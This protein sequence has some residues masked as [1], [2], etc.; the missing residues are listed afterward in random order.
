[1]VHKKKKRV[2]LRI[3]SQE[4]GIKLA[5]YAK[6]L[7]GLFRTLNVSTD[8]MNAVHK[9]IALLIFILISTVCAAQTDTLTQEID[10][11]Q[12]FRDK[13]PKP[14]GWVN[15]FEELYSEEQ[16]HSLDS[17]IS[18]YNAKTT[19]EIAIVTIDTSMIS[20]ERFEDFTLYISN[21]W[22]VGVK[23]KDNGILIGISNGY[24]RMRIQNG[25]GIEKIISDEETKEIIDK[26]FIPYF[27]NG[28]YYSGTLTGLTRL[29]AL[30]NSKQ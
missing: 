10:Y 3:E 7:V 13:L 25:Y 23:G 2:I 16:K 4:S 27:K 8:F 15:D 18:D 11:K 19:I 28:D 14:I 24:R 9:Y 30:L 21:T 1:V 22:G 5:G 29:I 6:V 12:L 17:I 20:D 26:Y